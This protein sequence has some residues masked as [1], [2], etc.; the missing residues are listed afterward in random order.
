MP[1][2]GEAQDVLDIE[3]SDLAVDGTRFI[4]KMQSQG[5]GVVMGDSLPNSSHTFK[6]Q[7]TYMV[8]HSVHGYECRDRN[9]ADLW[10]HP[11]SIVGLCYTVC[12]V[13]S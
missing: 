2:R 10:V 1:G 3:A 5:L 4:F 12:L 13:P 9:E 11:Q 8:R 6:G 7:V